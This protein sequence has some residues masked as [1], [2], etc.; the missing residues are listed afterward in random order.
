MNSLVRDLRGW[1]TR[2]TNDW[3]EDGY[4]TIQKFMKSNQPRAAAVAGGTLFS[5]SAWYAQNGALAVLNGDVAG[6][7]NLDRVLHYRWWN[8]RIDTGGTLV[9]NAA[10]TLAHAITFEE[11]SKA[12]WL[13]ERMLAS[14]DDLA[15]LTWE[16]SS[17]GVFLLK[18]WARHQGRADLNLDRPKVAKLGVYQRVFD[19]WSD[20]A[21]LAGAVA[22]MCDYHLKESFHSE[23]F[24][25]FT[26]PPYDL[27]PVDYLA[28]SIVRR[29]LGLATPRPDHPL[30][31]TPLAAPPPPESRPRMGEDPLLEMVLKKAR[32]TGFLPPDAA[33][34]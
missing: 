27:F 1:C 11:W 28:L 10:L 32:D 19:A 24:P 33:G 4:K 18:L 30:L 20:D 7:A 12:A 21:Q 3:R 16:C 22:D 14:I 17:F 29:E 2:P 31:A 8:A 13:A 9:S 15:F 5:L 34:P 23:G 26:D 25:Q 6:W